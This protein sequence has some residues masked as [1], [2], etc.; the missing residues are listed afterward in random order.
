MAGRSFSLPTLRL[1]EPGGE[2]GAKQKK[3][4]ILDEGGGK[5]YDPKKRQYKCKSIPVTDWNEQTKAEEWRR[6]WAEICNRFLEKSNHAE[7][8]DHRSYE[9]QG[10]EQI[11][12]VHLGVAA[13]QMERRGIRTERGDINRQAALDNKMLR[14]LRARI[15]K[16][17]QG[18][19]ELL[20]EA[21]AS[22]PI[23]YISFADILTGILENT[24]DKTRSQKITD[25]KTFAKAVAFVQQHNI[26]DLNGLH[27]KVTEMYGRQGALSDRL[28]KVSAV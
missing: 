24:E 27:D 26:A 13:F 7:Q 14:Q 6:G 3:E 22:H 5:I 16:L 1:F 19:D 10:I 9:R 2:W 28:K 4:Y 21:A 8:I 20:A 12:T 23:P 18:L 17:K 15:N 25:L 11:P